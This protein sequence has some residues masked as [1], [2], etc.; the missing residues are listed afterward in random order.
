MPKKK[1]NLTYEGLPIC[2]KPDYSNPQPITI[3]DESVIREDKKVTLYIKPGLS[4]KVTPDKA[5]PE[6]ARQYLQNYNN[7][8]AW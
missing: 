2:K 7:R 1:L 4:I 3:D 5:T 8:H 6:Y